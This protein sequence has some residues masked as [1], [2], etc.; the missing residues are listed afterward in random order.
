MSNLYAV[1]QGDLAGWNRIFRFGRNPDVDTATVPETVWPVG[2]VYS[3]KP[4]TGFLEVVSSSASDSSAG[5]G[6]RTVLIEG[7]AADYSEQ[8][9][10]LTLNG[11]A[12][13]QTVHQYLRVN[14]VTV[15]TSGTT[16]WNVGNLIIRDSGVG[17]TRAYVAAEIGVAESTIYTVPLSHDLL[18]NTLSVSFSGALIDMDAII[19]LRNGYRFPNGN[20]I[21]P[22]TFSI[23]SQSAPYYH[24]VIPPLF[25]PEKTDLFWE[26]THSTHNNIPVGVYWAGSL[27]HHDH[28]SHPRW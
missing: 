1:S 22:I 4:S 20:Q 16:G 14:H 12:A 19:T 21:R 24:E 3:W 25:V 15:A 10:F 13:V 9:E 11:L 5:V 18:I 17:P 26:V 27:V 2:G 8:F 7:L 6:A 28:I 23:T